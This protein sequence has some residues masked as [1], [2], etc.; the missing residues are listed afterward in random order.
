MPLPLKK[1]NQIIVSLHGDNKDISFQKCAIRGNLFYMT[2]FST[3]IKT[4][5]FWPFIYTTTMF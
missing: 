4:K 5:Q 3:K 2:L 1:K